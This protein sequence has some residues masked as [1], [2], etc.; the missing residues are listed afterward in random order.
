MINKLIH[1]VKYEF[2]VFNSFLFYRFSGLKYDFFSDSEVVDQIISKRR[3]LS[4][5]GDGEFKWMWNIKQTSFQSDN[6]IMSKR[7]EDVINSNNNNLIIG[8]PIGMVDV[9]KYNHPARKYWRLFTYLYKDKIKSTIPSDRFF[10]NTNISRCYI[11]YKHKENTKERFDNLKRIWNKRDVVIV[12]GEKTRLGVGNDLLDNVNALKR[13]IAPSTNAFD[14][15]DDIL[16]ECLKQDKNVLFILALGPTATILA[17]D[18]CDL[19]Y[20]AVDLGH[21]DIEYEWF[22]MGAKKKIP[23]EGKFVNEAMSDNDLSNS[24]IDLSEYNKSVITYI[25]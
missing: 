18:L 12:E 23:V 15:Y 10:A 24:Y 21:F 14:R 4:R 2:L 3:S 7:L 17:S 25:K 13:I 19:G 1:K 9:S 6:I 16:K 20:Q 5:F 8:I 11:D 22:R